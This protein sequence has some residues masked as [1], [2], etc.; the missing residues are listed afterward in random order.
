MSYKYNS[1]TNATDVVQMQQLV[2]K[3]QQRYFVSLIPHNVVKT[4]QMLREYNRLAVRLKNSPYLRDY[5]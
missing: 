4:Q 5:L 1:S 3:I 2:V